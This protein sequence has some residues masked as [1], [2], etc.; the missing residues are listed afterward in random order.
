MGLVK[1]SYITA[2][3]IALASM[4]HIYLGVTHFQAKS[5]GPAGSLCSIND[6]FDCAKVS[7][8]GYSEFLGL[9]LAIWG[10]AFHLFLI[11]FILGHLF[12]T[13]NKKENWAL[14]LRA[15]TGFSLF[16][17]LI[18]FV[19][20]ITQMSVYCLFC[21]LLYALSALIFGLA[22]WLTK[23]TVSTGN[24]VSQF[25]KNNFL[26]FG[27]PWILVLGIPVAT[28]ILQQ[29]FKA[30]FQ[31][32]VSDSKY[33]ELIKDWTES[34][35]RDFTKVA[36]L[37][38]TKGSNPDFEIVEFADFLCGFCGRTYR[39]FKDFLNPKDVETGAPIA[40]PNVQFKFYSFPL[41]GECNPHIEQKTGAS[42][43]LTLATE[44]AEKQ[45]QGWGV[46]DYIFDHQQQIGRHMKDL[47][48]L[49]KYFYEGLGKAA[50][51]ES[52]NMSSLKSCVAKKDYTN[53]KKQ[54]ELAQKIGVRGTPAVYL[55][56][57][58]VLNENIVGV[59]NEIYKRSEKK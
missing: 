5:G 34:S 10:A 57:R 2:F 22:L 41:D 44:C 28:L 14:W 32:D 49:K 43:F 38:A 18:M 31:P 58:K 59:I 15:L 1:K 16:M 42:C 56:G 39:E 17:S 46:H 53:I 8:S 48:G 29:S 20:S 12:A 25:F 13:D 23:H 11:F 51:A 40:K 37:M 24:W 21:M 7:L 4:V 54:I 36:P 6:T 33:N 52:L 45:K 30:S 55:K 26:E 47:D 27:T 3:V 19:I 50:V 35:L 9:P